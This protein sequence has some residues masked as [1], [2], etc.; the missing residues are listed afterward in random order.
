MFPL[1]IDLVLK[2]CLFLYNSGCGPTV[3]PSVRAALS[4][5]CSRLIITLPDLSDPRLL[6]LDAKV[7]E[8]RGKELKESQPVPVVLVA[9]LEIFVMTVA[10]KWPIMALF[11]GYVLCMIFASLRFDDALHARSAALQFT[12]GVLYGVR[13]QTKVERMRR[14]TKFAIAS[15]GIVGPEKIVHIMPTARPWLEVFWE[16]LQRLSLQTVIF[17]CMI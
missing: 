16:L 11:G 17:G 9:I 5:V 8:E 6:A 7:V 4:W 13:W 15:L 12:N 14:G 2:Y 3:I 1:S 10:D